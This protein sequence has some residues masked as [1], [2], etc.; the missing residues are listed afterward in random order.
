VPSAAVIRGLL[1]GEEVPPVAAKQWGYSVPFSIFR[2]IGLSGVVIRPQR[3]SLGLR[4]GLLGRKVL[5]RSV[6]GKAVASISLSTT[7][8]ISSLL[9]RKSVG[10]HGISV[11]RVGKRSSAYGR[12]L[13]HTESSA[14]VVGKAGFGLVAEVLGLL[15]STYAYVAVGGDTTCQQCMQHNGKTYSQ[16]DIAR[17]FPYAQEID[18]SLIM[19]NVHK[20]CRCFLVLLKIGA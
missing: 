2:R 11:V 8:N 9:R 10:V 6:H 20:W 4:A 19:P 18:Y 17:L 14:K 1:E 13:H 5:S 12:L 16:D 3:E 15:E 7:V